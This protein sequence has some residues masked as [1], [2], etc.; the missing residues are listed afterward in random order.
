VTRWPVCTCFRSAPSISAVLLRD[1]LRA[2]SALAADDC[3]DAR[4]VSGSH[5]RIGDEAM[6]RRGELRAAAGDAA[7]EP[8]EPALP[9]HPHVV[10]ARHERPAFGDKD[11]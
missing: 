7:A 2:E 5:A 4:H 6:T 10:V 8:L 9:M 1:P 11:R 3:F